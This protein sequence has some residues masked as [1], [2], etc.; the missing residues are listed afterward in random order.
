MK[1]AL[2]KL[3]VPLALV[4]LLATA[5]GS[6]T[7]PATGSSNTPTATTAPASTPTTASSALI[8]TASATVQG[9][10][11]TILTNAQGMTLYYRSNDT[12]TSVCS[13]GCAQ[14][15]PPL[16]STGSGTPASSST[17]P[18]TLSVATNANGSQVEY[19]GHPLYTY[20]SDTAPGQTNGENV[21]GIWFV[22]TTDLTAAGG[23]NSPTP[24][25]TSGGY[26]Y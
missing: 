14:T 19:Q 2:L 25:A 17:L 18:G 7:P 8:A 13:S 12:A 5:C 23:G 6:S 9:K 15:W 1:H 10:T 3:F 26:G 21:E 4:A 11:V 24:T 16:L 20:V 22:A